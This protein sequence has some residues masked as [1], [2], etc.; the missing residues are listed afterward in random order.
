VVGAV[1]LWESSICEVATASLLG[2]DARSLAWVKQ[3]T[4][5]ITSREHVVASQSLESV[6]A[7]LRWAVPFAL[8]DPAV[9]QPGS[10]LVSLGG[11]LVLPEV[12]VDDASAECS[13]REGV[14]VVLA[15]RVSSDGEGAGTEDL[16]V[17]SQLES[18]SWSRGEFESAL[19]LIRVTTEVLR[20]II[21]RLRCKAVAALD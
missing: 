2:K 7:S 1:K 16:D 14:D 15:A 5:C 20:I 13:S 3:E 11:V 4:V 17:V 9:P 21:A 19:S 10:L 12:V 8:G 6:L 18:V